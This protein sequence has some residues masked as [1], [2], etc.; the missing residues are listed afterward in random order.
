MSEPLPEVRAVTFDCWGT[1][2][3]E[4]D[5]NDARQ[6]RLEALARACERARSGSAGTGVDEALDA[7]WQ[8]HVSL[9][10]R[11]RAS[12]SLEI[13][14]WSLEALGVEDRSTV[15][16]LAREFAEAALGCP[17]QALDGALETLQALSRE[18]IRRALV[19]DT[20]FSPGRVVRRLLDR[21]GLLDELE[22]LVFSDEL[23]V[24]KPHARTFLTALEAL[25]VSAREAV[26]VGDLRRTDVAGARA[27]GLASIRIRAAH[28]DTSDLAEADRVADSHGHLCQL[29][30]V[31]LEGV[32]ATP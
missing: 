21:E 3:R 27:A 8:R 5:P 30:G 29:L 18:G 22:F 2:I 6:L 32:R 9:S 13:A 26:H 4:L 17:V 10:Q 7:A 12:G 31:S 20:G 19:C 11:G 25:G 16:P 14:R 23:G 1:L 24:P 15:D 28:D